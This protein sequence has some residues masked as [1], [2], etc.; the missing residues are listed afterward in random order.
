MRVS[1][2]VP[3]A[4]L[5][6]ASTGAWTNPRQEAGVEAPTTAIPRDGCVTSECHTSVKSHA[7][8]HG[9]LKVNACDSCHKLTDAGTHAYAMTRAS[10]ALCTMCHE[11]TLPE[12]YT[13]HKPV[14]TG[15]CTSCHDPHGGPGVKL[16]RGRSY[17]EMCA[18][19][20]K[21][22]I[23]ARAQL[24]GPA[25]AGA[26]GACH[27]P[28]ASEHPMLLSDVGKD[29]C[30]RCHVA[31]GIE[32]DTM[33]V[34]HEP[35]RGDCRICHDPHAT[36]NASL[37]SEDPVSLCTSC[38]S[39]IAHTVD[40]STTRHSA[41]VTERAC[42]NCH[43]PHASDHPRLLKKTA[44]ALCFEC[45]DKPLERPGGGTIANI[46]AVMEGSESLHGST[47]E[48]NC[49]AC[50][51]IHGSGNARL[52]QAE[53]SSDYYQAFKDSAYA[54]CFTCHDRQLVLEERTT[55]AT[56]FR[57]G[58]E[59]LHYVHV[60]RDKKG[61]S[62]RICHDSHAASR[63]H[64]I[65]SEV[66]FGPG[67]WMLPIAWEATEDGGTCSAACHEGYAYNRV[68]P[69]TYTARSQGSGSDDKTG[70]D[71]DDDGGDKE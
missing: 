71:S 19:C 32:L 31:T 49:A 70:D 18:S 41:V 53:F 62:C 16:L 43:D 63:T 25:S 1:W 60:N 66:P 27:E 65:R 52:L 37:L 5:L 28:H 47:A 24:H 51:Q 21:D 26:C 45:H 6:L 11:F 46:K 17:A 36:D 64:H 22:L 61:R 7:H 30:L 3:C 44:M 2:A 50:H 57:N 23:G 9:P 13:V 54:I 35:A 67:G 40:R 10:D 4:V 29:L 8:V 14:Q 59:N 33:H 42:L 38:H 48:Q 68:N 34:V 20:H 15:E 39:G 55:T 58:S 12:T 69:V 56:A